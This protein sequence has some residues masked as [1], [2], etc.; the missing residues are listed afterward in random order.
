M[1]TPLPHLFKLLNKQ[2][3]MKPSVKGVYHAVAYR[4]YQSINYEGRLQ[5]VQIDGNTLKGKKYAQEQ[6][7]FTYYQNF[8]YH[9]ALYGLDVYNKEEINKM[10][11]E[12]RRRIKKV[13][14][15][16]QNAINLLKQEYNIRWTN[17]LF[18]NFNKS[19]LAEEFI[20]NF[21]DPDRD[22]ENTM[23][24]KT[25]GITKKDVIDRL[26]QI[27]VLPYNFYDLK[28]DPNVKL[29]T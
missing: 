10:H 11:W 9:R 27:Q 20:S 12:K 4:M 25:L 22:Y 8:L 24:F 29:T 2:I 3:N 6:Y 15:K 23:T 7:S 28:N 13:H 17:E 5:D 14:K 26:I 18:K 16:V 19:S 1:D 21:S